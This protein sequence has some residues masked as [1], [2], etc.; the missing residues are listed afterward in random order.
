MAYCHVT[1]YRHLQWDI[2][3]VRVTSMEL[4]TTGGNPHATDIT[5]SLVKLADI[6]FRTKEV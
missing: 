6:V 4:C 2:Y 3:H 1:E 5:S